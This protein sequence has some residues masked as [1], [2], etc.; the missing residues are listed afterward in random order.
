MSKL[1]ARTV[2]KASGA[3]CHH[4]T[5]LPEGITTVLVVIVMVV[6]L[7][8]MPNVNLY[9]CLGQKMYNTSAMCVMLGCAQSGVLHVM[10]SVQSIQEPGH[11]VMCKA[12]LKRDYTALL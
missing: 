8:T 10:H 5:W 11:T 7:C 12:K 1:H 4:K 6:S 3:H 2:I 9:F